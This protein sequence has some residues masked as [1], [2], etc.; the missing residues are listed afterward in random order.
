M[1][2]TV[3]VSVIAADTDSRTISGRIVTWGEV[4]N[5]SAGKTIFAKDSIALKPVK[6]FIDHNM[7]K[8]VG[9]LLEYE[10]TDMGV[11]A[12]FSISKTQRGNDAI[13]E[14]MDGLKDGLSVGIKLTE[15]DN[16]DEGSRFR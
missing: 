16:T 6:L 12:R 4:G 15:Y 10:V 9:K 1:K 14:A 3:P 7:D 13:I 5:T 8:P 11:D 2:I